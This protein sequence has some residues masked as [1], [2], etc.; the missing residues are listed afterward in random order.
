MRR[1]D[2]GWETESE[3]KF[4]SRA[5]CQVES[6]P[7]GFVKIRF[8]DSNLQAQRF[9]WR[10]VLDGVIGFVE[11]FF[12]FHGIWFYMLFGFWSCKR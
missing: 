11:L 7:D 8:R 1:P 4:P 12:R 2:V 3:V 6:C 5:F 9:D 10:A